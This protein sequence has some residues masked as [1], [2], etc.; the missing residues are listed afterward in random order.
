[1]TSSVANAVSGGN[2]HG[3]IWIYESQQSNTFPSTVSALKEASSSIVKCQVPRMTTPIPPENRLYKS[4]SSLKELSDAKATFYQD[5][6]NQRV[7]EVDAKRIQKR[8]VQSPHSMRKVHVTIYF[9]EIRVDDVDSKLKG[10]CLHLH[11]GGWL[12]GDSYYQVAHRCLEMA[13]HLNAA[14]V[15]VEYSLLHHEHFDPVGDT[16][17]ALEWI[18][19]SGADE[20][21][22]E[23]AFVAS[24]ESSG[25]HLLLSAMLHRR[26][27][28]NQNTR[29]K[30]VWKCLNLV[31]GVYDLSGTPSIHHDG[32]K[33]FPLCGN[34]LLWL[35]DM[36]C[37]RVEEENRKYVS[38]LHADMSCMPPA[39]ISVGTADSL[40]DDSL[41]LAEK[42]QIYHNDLK[43]A[44]YE[45]GEHG[46]GH[47][48]VQE[49]EAMG[50]QAR[51]RT[52][53][54]MKEYL[55]K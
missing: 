15:S 12:W 11:G 22:S 5:Q 24:G 34:D 54:F 30:D 45:H 13:S 23:K 3:H 41:L 4:N 44:L 17:T 28:T 14:V 50:E 25:A 19:C 36:Y 51:R 32:D 43:V 10:I 31:Y 29:I 48:G 52:L 38:P 7:S 21:G 40:L 8:P 42:Y 1:M 20:L 35:Y 39:L 26:D 27:D 53:D 2:S 49:N 9:P 33:S 16:I 55:E 37:S 46:I 6:F 47:F 18:E